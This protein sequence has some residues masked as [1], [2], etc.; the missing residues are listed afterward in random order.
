MNIQENFVI[1][2]NVSLEVDRHLKNACHAAASFHFPSHA[3]EVIAFIFMYL[4][5][6]KLEMELPAKS[7]IK[8]KTFCFVSISLYDCERCR[9]I[10][11]VR[12]P[13]NRIVVLKNPFVGRA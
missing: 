5:E 9:C 10:P 7:R 6:W 2:Q 8:S 1:L 11:I 13:E 4:P 12:S 3:Y